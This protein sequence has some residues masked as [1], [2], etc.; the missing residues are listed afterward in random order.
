MQMALA[1]EATTIDGKKLGIGSIIFHRLWM[2]ITHNPDGT[3]KY[4][5]KVDLAKFLDSVLGTRH[6]DPTLAAY[7][8]QSFIAATGIE[9]ENTNPETGEVYPAKDVIKTFIAK[10]AA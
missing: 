1:Q 10:K 7:K 3:E 8:G 9:P 5:Y 2:V 4:N 6:W